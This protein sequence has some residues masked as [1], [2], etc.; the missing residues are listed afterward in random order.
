V[1]RL[2]RFVG[3]VISS[4]AALAV[5][6]LYQLGSIPLAL[7]YLTKEQFGLWVL[8]TQIA[9]YLLMI[10]FGITYAIARLLIDYKDRRDG[11]DYGSLLQTGWLVLAIQA[12]VILCLGIG[13]SP[14]IESG[15]RI[16]PEFH[17]DFPVL[18]RWLCLFQALVLT[19]RI[20]PQ[21]LYAHQRSDVVNYSAMVQQPVSFVVLWI[22]LR[23]GH[24]VYSYLLPLGTQWAMDMVILGTSCLRLGLLPRWGAWGRPSWGRFRELFSFGKDAFLVSIG[25]QLMMASQTVIVTRNLGL[26]AVAIWATCTK[27][28]ALVY[29]LLWRI[30]DYSIPGFSEMI[31]R[32]EM[33][34]LRRRWRDLTMFIG[35]VAGAG[36]IVFAACNQPFVAVWMHGEISW[37][38]RNDVLLAAWIVVNT[39]AH[40]HC[41]FVGATGK[42]GTMRYVYF[43]EGALFILL[44]SLGSQV[45]GMTAIIAASVL[46]TTF[47][48]GL[49]G[50]FHTARYCKFPLLEVAFGWQRP[51]AKLVLFL[52][53]V[54]GAVWW[55]SRGWSP[56]LRLPVNA[57]LVGGTGAALLLRY[58]VPVNLQTDISRALPA[59]VRQL[60]RR[61]LAW[62]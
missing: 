21:V 34:Q 6:M 40:A 49:Y 44:A 20:T 27:A 29:Q 50:I 41:A 19:T 52:A 13:L 22:S 46:C 28:Y 54:A 35:A 30:A 18:M 3:S 16:S 61:W 38:T 53:P 32:K 36:A 59:W 33:D 47:V 42:I 7:R 10:D 39:V 17:K 62:E 60:F 4:Y 26:A 15:L 48:S 51:M 37:P 9:G 45:A 43:V 1:T 23:A 14:H 24:G 5:S 2:K 8:M 12:V 25:L 55:T 56:I 57:A 31:V 11:G 58:G